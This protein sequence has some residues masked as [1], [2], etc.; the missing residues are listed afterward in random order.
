MRVFVALELPSAIKEAAAAIQ[1]ELITSKAAV[2]WVRAEGMHLTLKFLG[3][4]SP[5]QLP[6]IKEALRDAVE[7]TGPLK[8]S[9][10]GIGV[11]PNSK[12]P[13]V[14]WLGIQT[15]DD[16]LLQ[17]QE[18]IDRAL[19]VTGFPPEQ[20]GFRPHLTLGRIKSSRGLDEL[21]KA[22]AAQD[23]FLAGD[24]RLKELHLI[25][26]EL[27]TKWAVYTNLWSVAL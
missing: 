9:V 11:F 20:H 27:R 15:D 17:L 26:S 25:Q 10:R 7:G 23:R 6:G 16:R 24:C 13:R 12:N 3:E 22:V 18:R 1:R 5:S 4:V 21:M 2:G 8:I 14:V 19:E